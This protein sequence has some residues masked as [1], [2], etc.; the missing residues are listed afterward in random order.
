MQAHRCLFGVGCALLAWTGEFLRRIA[1]CLND[2]QKW[3]ARLASARRLSAA[4][5]TRSPEY[6]RR[7]ARPSSPPSTCWA[8]NGPRSCVG[9]GPGS[10]GWCCRSCRTRSSLPSPRWLARRSRSVASRRCCAHRL[11]AACPRPT[12]SICCCSSRFPASCSSAACT[13]RTT[14]RTST[15]RG[16]PRGACRPCWSTPPLKDL[17]FPCVS[18]D[19]AVAMEQAMGHL[20]SLGTP[21]SAC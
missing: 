6:P 21:G 14:H 17:D 7:P 11:P 10:W 2:L 15:T 4:S 1:T 13:P 3:L 19:D 9:S 5:S 18:C 16:W 12:T 20:L 8:T